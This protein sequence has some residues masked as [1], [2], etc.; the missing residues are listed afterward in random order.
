MFLILTIDLYAHRFDN[1]EIQYASRPIS[2]QMQVD[3]T[4]LSI[5][6]KSSSVINDHLHESHDSISESFRSHSDERLTSKDHPQS[7]SSVGSDIS[8]KHSSKHFDMDHMSTVYEESE[9]SSISAHNRVKSSVPIYESRPMNI[10]K[11]KIISSQTSPIRNQ[12]SKEKSFSNLLP[13]S[14]FGSNHHKKTIDAKSIITTVK[15]STSVDYEFRVQTGNESHLDGTKESVSI[16]LIN[17]KGQ[18]LRIPLTNSMNNSKPFQKGQLDIFHFNT[19]MNF[20]QVIKR[21]ERRKSI[22]SF[23]LQLG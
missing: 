15:S 9:P 23:F 4:V 14:S 5:E 11:S 1:S 21:I 20:Q 18:I 7:I 16:E 8:K 22:L 13:R 10:Q 12:K 3:E 19:P 17:T 2:S 6:Q